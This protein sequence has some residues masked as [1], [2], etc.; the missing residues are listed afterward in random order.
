M[1]TTNIFLVVRTDWKPGTCY[2]SPSCP[3]YNEVCRIRNSIHLVCLFFRNAHKPSLHPLMR[4][5][6][7]LDEISVTES[8]PGTSHQC[9]HFKIFRLDSF[10][11]SRPPSERPS[12]PP[13]W[14]HSAAAFPVAASEEVDE[15]SGRNCMWHP[16][17]HERSQKTPG[18]GWVTNTSGHGMSWQHEPVRSSYLIEAADLLIAS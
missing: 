7:I 3:W 10:G 1:G 4:I 14:T 13:L 12:A 18:F 9:H 5:Q 2:S 17:I 15:P 8:S 16:G 6:N 11:L